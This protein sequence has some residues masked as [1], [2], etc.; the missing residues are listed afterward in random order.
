MLDAPTTDFAGCA[1]LDRDRR[2]Q[3]VDA[4]RVCGGDLVED[5]PFANLLEASDAALFVCV[6]DAARIRSSAA[7]NLLAATDGR[8]YVQAT[9][10]SH[11]SP[12]FLG[13]AK[14]QCITLMQAVLICIRHAYKWPKHLIASLTSGP[15]CPVHLGCNSAEIPVTLSRKYGVAQTQTA[16]QRSCQSTAWR[17]AAAQRDVCLSCCQTSPSFGTAHPLQGR[18]RAASPPTARLCTVHILPPYLKY[19]TGHRFTVTLSS[20]QVHLSPFTR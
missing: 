11:G 5:V 14:L 7:Q 3:L 10:A 20:S 17:S 8:G 13:P 18:C 19:G 4:P 1:R 2:R 12:R 9:R 16:S 6:D 15:E